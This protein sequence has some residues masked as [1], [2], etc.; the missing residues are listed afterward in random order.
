MQHPGKDAVISAAVSGGAAGASWFVKTLPVVQWC[1]AVVAIV[2]GL[3]AIAI[4][5]IKLWT[6]WRSR[7]H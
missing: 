4:G 6:W 1:A 5:G 3:I 2:S 7:R